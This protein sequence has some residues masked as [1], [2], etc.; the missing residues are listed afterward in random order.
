MFQEESPL[1]EVGR[2]AIARVPVAAV[3]RSWIQSARWGIVTEAE[4]VQVW[5]WERRM[6]VRDWDK[7]ADT[8]VVVPFGFSADGTKLLLFVPGTDGGSIRD[9][10][11]VSGHET[12]SIKFLFPGAKSPRRDRFAGRHAHGY[13][14]C[15][16]RGKRAG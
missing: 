8:S 12:R 4:K 3:E 9:W 6:L 2:I 15:G 16:Q 14:L 7:P 5:D 11:L 1:L 13:D 10:D